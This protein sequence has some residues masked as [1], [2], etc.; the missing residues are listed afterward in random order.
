ML[1][2]VRSTARI[3]VFALAWGLPAAQAAAQQPTPSAAAAAQGSPADQAL[4]TLITDN[5][6][7]LDN[8]VQY[9]QARLSVITREASSFP[10]G[11]SAGGFT[12]TFD[13]TIG[14]PVR[15]SRSFGPMFADRPLT[16]GRHKV[17]VSLSLQQRSWRALGGIDLNKELTA[18]DACFAAD[19]GAANPER[20][21]SRMQMT[22][23]TSR[24][25]LNLAYGLFDRMD[26][27]VIV[28]Y[29]QATVSG[30]TSDE[31]TDLTTGASYG[32]QRGSLPAGVSFH[33]ISALVSQH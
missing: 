6:L 1:V 28:P 12:Y 16:S 33:D 29:G 4:F 31:L 26:I 15:R 18:S 3:L 32:F 23:R 14:L 27:R 30:T 10:I 17:S 11:S 22:F 5:P 25:V 13:P 8:T 20:D 21:F 9:Y 19:L 7:S 2:N 24:Q